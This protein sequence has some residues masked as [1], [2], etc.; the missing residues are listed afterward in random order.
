MQIFFFTELGN[1]NGS[2]NVFKETN[3]SWRQRK[4][5]GTKLVK[6]TT[7]LADM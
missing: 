6:D 5:S 1:V 7:N 2:N 3:R 4:M